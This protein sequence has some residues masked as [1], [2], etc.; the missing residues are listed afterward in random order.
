MGSS[1]PWSNASAELMMNCTPAG[2]ERKADLV[3]QAVRLAGG[4]G[5]P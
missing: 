3:V 4:R 5:G 1:T 2:C